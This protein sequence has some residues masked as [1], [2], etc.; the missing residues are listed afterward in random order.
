MAVGALITRGLLVDPSHI[1]TRGLDIGAAVI[2]VP[3]KNPSTGGRVYPHG[4]TVYPKA[5]RRQLAKKLK[6][7][8]QELA[9]PYEASG[10]LGSILKAK[11][12]EGVDNRID[13]LRNEIER[14]QAE[15][16]VFKYL[17]RERIVKKKKKVLNFILS[18]A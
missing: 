17:E 11:S 16:K 5:Y 15:R 4:R 13:A 8:L 6:K 14:I 1:V 10:K 18:L 2:V 12:L 7:E 9:I 3:N